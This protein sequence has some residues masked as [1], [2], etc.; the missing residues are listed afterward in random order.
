MKGHIFL[1][2]METIMRI[3]RKLEYLEG[4]V[5]L[6]KRKKDEKTSMNWVASVN[7]TLVVRRISVNKTY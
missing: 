3:P 6:D 7:Y 4:L 5:K 2:P 1:T